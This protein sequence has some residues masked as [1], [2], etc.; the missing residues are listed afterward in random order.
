MMHAEDLTR[1]TQEAKDVGLRSA[2]NRKDIEA[3]FKREERR[4][5]AEELRFGLSVLTNV[6]RDRMV[7]ALIELEQ[8]AD[9]TEGRTHYRVSS[10]LQALDI[11]LETNERLST[12]IDES[13]LL[14]GLMLA[15][16][17]L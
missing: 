3:Q 16:T 1:R 7:A 15:L 2:G 9:S 5:R 12:N 11:L 13:L 17:R 14:V 10:S 6:Y 8:S 4:F